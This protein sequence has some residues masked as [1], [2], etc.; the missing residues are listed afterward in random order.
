MSLEQILKD[1]NLKTSFRNMVNL[2]NSRRL[3]RGSATT[4]TTST[5]TMCCKSATS[6]L[7]QALLRL[8]ED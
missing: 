1:F 3:A 6:K 2:D 4:M 7:L 8:F 5:T